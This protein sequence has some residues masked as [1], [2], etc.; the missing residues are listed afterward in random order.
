M[1]H[2]LY[3]FKKE[4]KQIKLKKLF[5]SLQHIWTLEEFALLTFENISILDC[6]AIGTGVQSKKKMKS[7]C[8]K[9]RKVRRSSLD[10]TTHHHVS[11][12]VYEALKDER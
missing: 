12:Y 5:S 9:V 8:L 1:D 6:V 2:L 10:L 4:A 7:S 11:S 3:W